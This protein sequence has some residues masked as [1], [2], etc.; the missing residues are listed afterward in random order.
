[1]VEGAAEDGE[2]VA[3][4]MIVAARGG[5]WEMAM[6]RSLRKLEWGEG[7]LI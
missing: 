2:A 5:A 7:N 1:M 6:D 4:G 3:R